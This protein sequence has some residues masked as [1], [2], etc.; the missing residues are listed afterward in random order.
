MTDPSGRTTTWVIYTFNFVGQSTN[1][2]V[3]NVTTSGSRPTSW[4]G[5]VFEFNVAG[6][7][8]TSCVLYGYF[9]GGY[10]GTFTAANGGT[11]TY[12]TLP[13]QWNPMY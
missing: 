10:T 13:P 8:S 6:N 1:T 2:S 12:D 5:S 3:P 11:V 4:P 7:N 9:W